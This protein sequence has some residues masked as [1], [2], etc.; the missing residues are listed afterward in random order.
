MYQWFSTYPCVTLDSGE[1]TIDSPSAGRTGAYAR[2][3]LL[4][5]QCGQY[6]SADVSQIWCREVNLS[7]KRRSDQEFAHFALCLVV[8][9]PGFPLTCLQKIVRSHRVFTW[10]READH[11]WAISHNFA[12]AA[13]R[14]AELFC[15]ICFLVKCAASPQEAAVACIVHMAIASVGTEKSQ[16][17]NK[18]VD[19]GVLPAGNRVDILDGHESLGDTKNLFVTLNLP[20][21]EDT[22]AGC[23]NV[24]SWYAQRNARFNA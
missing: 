22:R 16:H 18:I 23:D 24:W 12:S 3:A 15:G 5:A 13:R 11:L 17:A 10:I 6:T 7:H 20:L 1:Q 8:S 2:D 4:H 9:L 14:Q 21:Y 19:I